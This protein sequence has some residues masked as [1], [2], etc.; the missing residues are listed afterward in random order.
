M[1]PLAKKRVFRCLHLY[2][3]SSAVLQSVQLTSMVHNVARELFLHSRADFE[4]FCTALPE[5]LPL[6]D[7]SAF[8]RPALPTY[9]ELMSLWMHGKLT[10]WEGGGQW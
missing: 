7:G 1:A 9:G 10:T 2:S 8:V 6:E 3:P 5:F 4:E